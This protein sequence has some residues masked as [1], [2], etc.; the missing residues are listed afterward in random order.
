MKTKKT[1][2]TK[3]KQKQNKTKL[4]P[5]D[6]NFDPPVEVITTTEKLIHRGMKPKD[7]FTSRIHELLTNGL[8]NVCMSPE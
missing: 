5:T 4:F 3:T 6:K 2:K 1:K 7:I 8:L